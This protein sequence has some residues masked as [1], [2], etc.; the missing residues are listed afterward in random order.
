M[1]EHLSKTDNAYIKGFNSAVADGPDAVKSWYNTAGR[2]MMLKSTGRMASEG[3][4]IVNGIA[5]IGGKGGRLFARGVPV[6]GG[7]VVGGLA[8]MG[9]ADMAE[10]A[11]EVVANSTM[12]G[13]F[14]LDATH[15]REVSSLQ[16]TVIQ[17]NRDPGFYLPESTG[18]AAADAIGQNRN[19][20]KRLLQEGDD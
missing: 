10:A 11:T 3:G 19:M 20:L 17:F 6:L 4:K 1:V 5:N 13:G 2:N 18:N 12:V 16:K 7:V 15:L 14:A 9:G 8:L